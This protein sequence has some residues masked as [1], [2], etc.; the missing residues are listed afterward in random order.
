MNGIDAQLVVDCRD[1]AVKMTVGRKNANFPNKLDSDV[2]AE[3]IGSAGLTAD[4]QSTAVKHTDLVQYYASDWD[5]ILARAE[6]NGK[7]CLADDNTIAIQAP[8]LGQNPVLSLQYGA[9]MLEFDAEIDARHQLKKVTSRAWNPAEQ[10]IATTEAA[11][12]N[13]QLNGNLTTGELAN[14]IGLADYL[15]DH[16]GTPN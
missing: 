12:P 3:L 15:Q 14:V 2:I 10:R 1:R 11:D 7:V 8:Q 13:V 16:G 4:V 5:F 9:T 6:A